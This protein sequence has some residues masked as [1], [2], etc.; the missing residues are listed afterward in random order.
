MRFD[1]LAVHAAPPDPATGEV[2]PPIRLSTTFARDEH[3]AL[4]GPHNYVRESNP[5]QD[6]LEGAMARLEGG[7]AAL[8]FASGMAAG[9]AVLQALPRGAHVVFPDDAYYGTGIVAREFLPQWGLTASFVPTDDLARLRAEMR[10]ETRLLW[11]E[12]PS[13]P[14]LK[15][16]DVRAASALAHERGALVLVDNTFPTPALTQPLK[17]G[18]DLVLHATTKYV[19]G[20]SDVQGGLLVFSRQ[21]ALH[22]Q[23]FH[24]RHILGAVAS[25]FNAWLALRGLRTLGCRMERHC[26][27]ALAVARMLAA[28]PRVLAVHYPGLPED[29]GHAVAA[30]QMLAPGGM[31]S[32]HVRGGREAAIAAVCRTQVFVRATSLGSVE[33]LIEHRATSEGVHA[34]APPDLVRLSVGLEHPDDLVEDLTQALSS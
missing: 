20:H 4:R 9:V 14:L 26:G 10:A 29:P 31:L 28:H 30:R 22:E 19:G 25:P 34:T 8:A 23:V 18:A 12:T 33:S 13:N 1:T 6:L 21:D 32:F 17:L 5:T 3:N 27:N 16:T 24:V 2:A 11:L 7:E 15:V